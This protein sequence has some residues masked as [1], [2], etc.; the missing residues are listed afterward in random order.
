MLIAHR[1]Y[2]SL[3]KDN[4]KE[5]FE[6]AIKI[7]YDMIELDVN[8][9]KTGEIVIYHDLTIYGKSI[10]EYH[11]YE[12]QEHGVITLHEYFHSINRNIIP[13]YVDVK[14]DIEVMKHVINY[15]QCE[16]MIDLSLVYVATFNI[17][18]LNLLTES[19]LP[20]KYG[21][22]TS[23]VFTNTE[24]DY[25]IDKCH[26]FSFNWE[27]FNNKIFEYINKRNKYVFLYTCHD[28]YEYTYIT[29]NFKNHGI[30]SNL[31]ISKNI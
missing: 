8:I 14:G 2:S 21:L 7:G 6:M 5:S 20:I 29:K 1:G 25:L 4:S 19:K 16:K 12:L 11:L 9:C 28:I 3:F 26:F 27:C 30:I 10:T 22:V 15:L 13:T 31:Y 17:Q 24:L 18:Q 23:N